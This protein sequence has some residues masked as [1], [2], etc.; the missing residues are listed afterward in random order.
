MSDGT[1][2]Q[3]PDPK[4]IAPVKAACCDALMDDWPILFRAGNSGQ[5]F[6]DWG[7][8]TDNVRGSS[9]M[10]CEF[11]QDAKDD[12]LFIAALINA[13]RT[14]ELVRKTE[15]FS[16]AVRSGNIARAVTA[17]NHHEA[18]KKA[19]IAHYN[20]PTDEPINPGKIFSVMRE[21]DFSEDEV[22]MLS[23]KVMEDAGFKLRELP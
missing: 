18:A 19:A 11:P 13:Y 16:F 8:C 6:E 17:R 12:A 23:E 9:L 21:G 15:E 20:D 1:N 10:D 14:G 4:L 5:D 2:F 3:W 22:Y 7:I